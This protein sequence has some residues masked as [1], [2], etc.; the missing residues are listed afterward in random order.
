LAKRRPDFLGKIPVPLAK[1]PSF[2]DP[3]SPGYAAVGPCFDFT[4]EGW[5]LPLDVRWNVG[6]LEKW[7]IGLKNGNYLDLIL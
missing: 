5:R 4:P 2:D 3:A 1:Y 7:N 6:M